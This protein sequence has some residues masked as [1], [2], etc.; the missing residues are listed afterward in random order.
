LATVTLL[1]RD[2]T[3]PFAAYPSVAREPLLAAR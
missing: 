3:A 2:G 1:I